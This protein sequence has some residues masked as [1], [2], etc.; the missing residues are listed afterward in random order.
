MEE[1]ESKE[2]R[3]CWIR[4]I[5]TSPRTVKILKELKAWKRATKWM[6]QFCGGQVTKSTWWMPRH[7]KAKKDAASCEKLRGVASR[8]WSGDLRMGQ[9]I[10]SYV[11]ISLI[12]QN[13]L[14]KRNLGKWNIS[15]PKGKEINWDCVSSGE[16]K[17]MS[18]NQIVYCLGLR[19]FNMEK[20][21]IA[22]SVGKLNHR[23]W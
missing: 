18:L 8:L 17:R 20:T 3:W 13:R 19:D 21:S 4:K 16:R 12:E 5:F 23:G 14:K 15:V 9:P 6:K 2:K 10:W 1:K 22:Q 11:Q 7:Q